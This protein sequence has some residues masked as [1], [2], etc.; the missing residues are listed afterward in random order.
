MQK[1]LEDAGI[2]LDSVAAEVLS[3]S[4]RLMLRA[5]IAG[6]GIRKRW[7]NWPKASCARR[8]RSCARR[9]A[10]RS[11]NGNATMLRITLEHL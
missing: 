10:V 7:R 2:K 9:Y 4:G 5:L 11:I 8:S 3:V 1:V 6:E